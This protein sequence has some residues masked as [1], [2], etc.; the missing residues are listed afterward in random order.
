MSNVNFNMKTKFE[1][2]GNLHNAVQFIYGNKIDEFRK[3]SKMPEVYDLVDSSPTVNDL[4]TTTVVV[5]NVMI[6]MVGKLHQDTSNEMQTENWDDNLGGS[7][8]MPDNSTTLDSMS[9]EKIS[10]VTSHKVT[11]RLDG[12][13]TNTNDNE[14]EP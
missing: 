9:A 11:G 13:L 12:V 1:N 6:P 2:K 4:T 10:M 8:I 14:F 5:P 7:S 3:A